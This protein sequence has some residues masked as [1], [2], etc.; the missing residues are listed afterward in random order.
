[1]NPY[2]RA[3]LVIVALA[4]P[5]VALAVD[6]RVDFGESGSVTNWND[7]SQ[8]TAGIDSS[9]NGTASNLIDFNSG[10][11]TGVNLTSSGFSLTDQ[12]QANGGWSH[13]N[14]DWVAGNDVVRDQLIGFSSGG[15]GVLTFSN[16]AD[17]NYQVQVIAGVNFPNR[18]FTVNVEGLLADADFLNNGADGSNINDPNNF[19]T[20]SSVATT[21]GTLT[22]NVGQHPSGIPEFGINALRILSLDD[23][24]GVPTP[25]PV[26]LASLGGLLLTIRRMRPRAAA[27]AHRAV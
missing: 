2:V 13:G 27:E 6:I 23:E 12:Q 1:M 15:P 14:V 10:A 26:A 24:V 3:A 22:V 17:G 9:G 16:L 25:G 8:L 7:F 4:N 20:W 5:A 18:A 11:G 21:A 19:L